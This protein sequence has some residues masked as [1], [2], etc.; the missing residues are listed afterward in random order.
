MSEPF[1]HLIKLHQVSDLLTRSLMVDKLEENNN[2]KFLADLRKDR[3]CLHKRLPRIDLN[4]LNKF[5]INFTLLFSVYFFSA[6]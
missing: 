6:P 2:G 4:Y 5:K 1:D 3:L